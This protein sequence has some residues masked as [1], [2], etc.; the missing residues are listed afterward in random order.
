MYMNTLLEGR[1]SIDLSFYREQFFSSVHVGDFV[2]VP[3][4]SH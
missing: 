1:H 2:T 4:G 3:P